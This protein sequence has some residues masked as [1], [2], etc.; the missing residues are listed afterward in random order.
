ML[1]KLKEMEYVEKI[2][3]KITNL[4]VTGGGDLVAQ[5]RQLFVPRGK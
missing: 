2:S 3:D 5:L 4:S 1:F